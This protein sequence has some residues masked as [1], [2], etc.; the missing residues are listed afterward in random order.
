MWNRYYS[1]HV[2]Q[3]REQRL[4]EVKWFAHRH[5]V[6]E[7]QSQDWNLGLSRFSQVLLF[8]EV[9][10]EG[11]PHMSRQREASGSMLV[12]HSFGGGWVAFHNFPSETGIDRLWYYSQGP[13]NALSPIPSFHGFD[14]RS[15]YQHSGGAG[16]VIV[17]SSRTK[18]NGRVVP[19]RKGCLGDENN[20][21]PDWENATC[22]E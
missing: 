21:A 14:H 10:I 18:W 8:G 4:Q 20:K 15:C 16:H 19:P 9:R 1:S 11:K 12:G 7:W 5:G 17:S 3:M 22:K 13:R 6:R 2:L